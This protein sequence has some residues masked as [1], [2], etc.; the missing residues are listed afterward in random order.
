M[1]NEWVK[2]VKDYHSK[3]PELTYKQCMVKLS[4]KKNKHGGNPL[5]IAEAVTGG[6]N[7]IGGVAESI[8]NQIEQGRRTTRELV[9]VSRLIEYL[10]LL[11]NMK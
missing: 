3:H 6:L 9:T 5:A 11:K 2:K 4:K 8:G 7:A 10:K 1:P